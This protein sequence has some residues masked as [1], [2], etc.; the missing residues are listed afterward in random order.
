MFH[1]LQ[2]HFAAAL[3][4]PCSVYASDSKLDIGYGFGWDDNIFYSETQEEDEVF[5]IFD[6]DYDY[7]RDL[8]E[9]LSLSVDAV[10]EDRH[11]NGESNARDRF[12]SGLTTLKY[13]GDGYV[14]GGQIDP[15]YSQFVTSDTDGGLVREGKQRIR[16]LKTRLFVEKDLN[17]KHSVEVG[18]EKKDKDYRDSDSDYDADI[19]D[20]RVRS[21]INDNFSLS[22]G[23][24]KEDRDY[25]DRLAVTA[26]GVDVAGDGLEIERETLFVKGTWWLSR[27]HKYSLEYKQRDNE[28]G[29]QGY[30]DNDKDQI[31]F[32]SKYRWDN[33]VVLE[34]KIKLS[35]K[36]YDEQLADDGGRLE[37]DKVGVDIELEVPMSLMLGSDFK[38][39]YTKF[40]LEWDDYESEQAS[41]EYEKTSIWFTVHKVFN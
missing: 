19:F 12:F 5:G 26:L 25:D 33:D 15:Q 40:N 4:I 27:N 35:D 24:E 28:D 7:D 21:K 9:K 30:Y 32:R 2:P 3:V 17:D 36:S 34:T 23:V 29:R 20:V 11:F 13:Q 10:Y 1:K 14:L 41:R 39:L 31:T 8:S 38:D 22:F 18:Y 37:S 6:L 16:T